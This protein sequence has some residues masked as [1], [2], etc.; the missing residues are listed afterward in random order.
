MKELEQI[1]ESV[2]NAQ[3]EN[4][5]KDIINC[6]PDKIN[7]FIIHS[8][9]TESYNIFLVYG[10]KNGVFNHIYR[11]LIIGNNFEKDNIYFKEGNV[12][13][14]D[15]YTLDTVKDWAKKRLNHVL[16]QI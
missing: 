11:M 12:I 16:S 4:I 3:I 15:S 1:K 2:F 13:C 8:E 7:N 14:N 9:K 10:V 5:K 6:T